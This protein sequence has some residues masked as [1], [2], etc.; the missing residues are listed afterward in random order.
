MT[1]RVTITMLEDGIA[2]VRINRPDKMNRA[3]YR[4]MGGD[5]RC[6]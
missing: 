4:A 2:D 6:D 5:R 3:R 1:D